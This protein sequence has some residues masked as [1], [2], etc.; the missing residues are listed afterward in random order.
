MAAQGLQAPFA[1]MLDTGASF[2]ATGNNEVPDARDT[3]DTEVRGVIRW[4]SKHF[5]DDRGRNWDWSFGG[6]IGFN[7]K[8]TMVQVKRVAGDGSGV[9]GTAVT[10]NPQVMFWQAF[11]WDFGPRINIP[12]NGNFETGRVY[13]SRPDEALESQ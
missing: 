13:P 3:T 11:W 9:A 5:L 4:E 2:S 8:L 6:Q 10:P 12:L 1:A 7:P